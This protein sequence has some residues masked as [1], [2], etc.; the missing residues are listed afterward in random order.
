MPAAILATRYSGS[1]ELLHAGFAIPAG[2]VLGFAAVALA[3]RA[4]ARVDLTLGRA[5]RRGT[6]RIG[7]ALGILGVCLASAAVVSLLVYALLKSVE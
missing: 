2:L 6:A 4:R 5:G 1:Y 7:R 3:R